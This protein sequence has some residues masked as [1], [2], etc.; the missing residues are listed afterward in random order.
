MFKGFK[1]AL[2]IA[3]IA[4]FWRSVYRVAELNQGFNGP[5][6]HNQGLFIGFEGVLM[7]IS[8]AALGAFHP[9]LCL[10]KVVVGGGKAETVVEVVKMMVGMERKKGPGGE[11][12]VQRDQTVVQWLGTREVSN[13]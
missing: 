11:R 3:T 8:V 4:I 1:W 2:G 13:S 9:L 10:G 5:L 12:D 7:A 6:T